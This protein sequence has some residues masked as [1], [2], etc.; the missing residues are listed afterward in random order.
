MSRLPGLPHAPFQVVLRSDIPEEWWAQP[1][2]DWKRNAALQLDIPVERLNWSM[3]TFE[4][5]DY[6][7]CVEYMQWHEGSHANLDDYVPVMISSRTL[8]GDRP[9]SLRQVLE[10]L[11]H[12]GKPGLCWLR[13]AFPDF[14]SLPKHYDGRRHPRG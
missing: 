10:G 5:P 3:P 9:A 14:P 8:W 7:I 11:I 4:L 1:S 6:P 2:E 12:E 13:S